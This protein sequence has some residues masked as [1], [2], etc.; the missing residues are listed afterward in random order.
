MRA[1]WV[2]LLCLAA[3]AAH[4]EERFAVVDVLIDPQGHELAAYEIHLEAAHAQLV[5][6]EGGDGVF[7]DP[8]T[9]D[10]EALATG[11]VV[12]ATFTLEAELPTEEIRVAR[13]HVLVEEGGQPD[14]RLLSAVTAD[15]K[16]QKFSA[17][18]RFSN[19]G[20]S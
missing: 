9:Y 5:G 11:R 4:A 2:L 12:L 15:A 10:S 18:V 20:E 8:P 13:L 19:G 6:V 3:G 17:R 14:L 16:G 7:A 1:A